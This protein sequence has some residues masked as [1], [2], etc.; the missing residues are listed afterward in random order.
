MTPPSSSHIESHMTSAELQ[1]LFLSQLE[2]YLKKKTHFNLSDHRTFL[3]SAIQHSLL[4]SGKRLRPLLCLASTSMVVESISPTIFP[5]LMPIAASIEI[6]HTYS[7]IHDDLPSMDNDTL[8]RGKPTCHVKFGEDIAILAGD[9][10][11]TLAFELLSHDLLAH[12]P[13]DTCISIINKL[14]V[15]SGMNGM[16]GGQAMDLLSEKRNQKSDITHIHSLKTG[17]LIQASLTLP[18]Q[19]FCD[20]P[21]VLEGIGKIGE[22]IGL[23]YQIVDDILD[24]EGNSD[25]MGKSKFKD[26]ESNK[27][28][29]VSTYG[30]A[31][32]KEIA[33]STYDKT[34]VEL[35]NLRLYNTSMINQLLDLIFVRDH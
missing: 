9:T 21:L 4:E 11:N 8:R 30:L 13:A 5:T 17:K 7:L 12:V 25:L 14:S 23:L 29:Y 16:A 27:Q 10:L 26:R 18:A 20:D 28:T 31:K 24:E 34:K 3:E 6:I 35:Q 22:K 19:L 2:D 1:T 32:T 15:A 33:Q